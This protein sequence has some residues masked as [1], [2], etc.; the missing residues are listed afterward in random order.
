MSDSTSKARRSPTAIVY[1]HV[2]RTSNHHVTCAGPSQSSLDY[3]VALVSLHLHLPPITT[4]TD[5]RPHLSSLRNGNG[6]RPPTDPDE[7]HGLRSVHALPTTTALHQPVGVGCVA[8]AIV[9]D[10]HCTKCLGWSGCL[11]ST[12]HKHCNPVPRTASDC[13]SSRTRYY[14]PGW[15]LRS[16]Q[17]TSYVAR[18]HGSGLH[19]W[20]RYICLT[21]QPNICSHIC[22][23]FSGGI[24]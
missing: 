7:Q 18:S 3:P 10:L 23:L 14:S 19:K 6:S 11:C 8:T 15:H 2:S 20:L 9:L 12:S 5:S 16:R 1:P 13:S 22:S 21:K 4:S 17:L 24:W